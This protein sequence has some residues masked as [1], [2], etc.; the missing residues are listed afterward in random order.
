VRK[1][2]KKRR[3]LENYRRERER[4]NEGKW[5]GIHK[6]AEVNKSVMNASMRL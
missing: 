2:W 3:S 4:R 1:P 6:E 5:R